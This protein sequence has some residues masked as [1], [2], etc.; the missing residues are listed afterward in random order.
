M[1]GFP[2][3]LGILA[4]SSY[5]NN[6]LV[7]YVLYVHGLISR[8]LYLDIVVSLTLPLAHYRY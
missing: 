8:L 3:Q 4:R 1:V 2:F 7:W 6:D 5:H